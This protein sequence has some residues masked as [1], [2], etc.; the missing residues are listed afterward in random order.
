MKLYELTAQWNEIQ[1]MDFD[2]QTIDDTLESIEGDIKD[3]AKNIGFVNANFDAQIDAIDKEVS[4]LAGMKK[5]VTNK[6]ESLKDYLRMNMEA[7][8]IKKIE[9]ELFTITLRKPSD[10]VVIDDA[11][12]VPRDYYRIVESV[13]KSMVKKALKDG[14]VVKGARLGKGKVGVMIK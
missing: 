4:R 8:G 9:C 10:I 12:S 11:E 13:D 2:S 1:S 5:V 7:T 3:K 14:H 6:Q